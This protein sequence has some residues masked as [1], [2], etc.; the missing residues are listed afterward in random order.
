MKK[1]TKKDGSPNFALRV[2]APNGTPSDT[3]GSHGTCTT[4][5]YYSKK[6]GREPQL[7]VVHARTRGKLFDVT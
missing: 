3:S 2:R 4:V 6:K 7:P 5:H 1:K